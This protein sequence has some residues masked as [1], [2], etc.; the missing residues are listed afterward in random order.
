M[1]KVIY[2]FLIALSTLCFSFGFVLLIKNASGYYGIDGICFFWAG[3][4]LLL[5]TILLSVAATTLKKTCKVFIAENERKFA[6]AFNKVLTWISLSSSLT[7][8]AM[9][10]LIMFDHGHS[11]LPLIYITLLTSSIYLVIGSINDKKYKY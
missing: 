7:A 3:M 1:K 9:N 5:V 6:S 8:I 2:L 10:V 4:A 11:A